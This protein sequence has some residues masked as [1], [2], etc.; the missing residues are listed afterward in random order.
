MRDSEADAGQDWRIR[1]ATTAD[2][3]AI[4]ELVTA[5]TRR[6][7]LPDQPESAAGKLLAWMTPAAL[8]ARIEAG[9]R[10][11]LAEV[12]AALAGVVA[13]RDDCHVHLLFVD[14]SFQRRGI[15][16]ALWETA[17]S[18]CVDAARPARI[19]VNASAYAVPVYRRLGFVEQA[20]TRLE[21]GI[22]TTPMEFRVASS[23]TPAAEGSP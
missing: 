23:A 12:G 18:A 4:S 6:Y 9:H 5:L 14:T 16:R 8:A 20:P 22:V 2:A 13:T 17:L 11:H 15:A 1:L 21:E 7:V 19:T 10:H 3:P